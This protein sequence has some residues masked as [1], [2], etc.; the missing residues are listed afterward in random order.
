MSSAIQ[1]WKAASKSIRK[2]IE[3]SIVNHVD[4]TGHRVEGKLQWLHVASNADY[5]Y[6]FSHT[7]RGKE[8]LQSDRFTLARLIRGYTVHDCWSSYFTFRDCKHAIC[9]AHLLREL[10]A[11]TEAGSRWAGKMHEL[12]LQ[13]YKASDY[14]KGTLKEPLPS[15]QEYDQICQQ[16]QQEEPPAQGHA[17]PGHA[18]P[19]HARPGYA[20][21]GHARP[22]RPKKTKGR[23]LLERFIKHKE[24]ILAF[25]LQEKVPFTNNQAE[26]DLRPAKIKQKVSGCFR[27]TA[28]AERYARI[29]SF[30][31]TA[32]KQGEQVFQQLY[33]MAGKSVV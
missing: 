22:G 14:G 6:L 20:R 10:T 26:R 7:K 15:L 1:D 27:T 16:G 8:A 13:A 21:P 28:G 29:Q 23:N 32:R 3:E 2:A 4:E 25:A 17:R 12:M 9:G 24:A 11:L 5:T 18:R 33:S 30:I 19:G 31:S